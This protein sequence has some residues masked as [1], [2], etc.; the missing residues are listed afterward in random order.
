MHGWE[1]WQWTLYSINQV[2]T[3]I[4]YYAIPLAGVHAAAYAKRMGL[5]FVP[6]GLADDL[7]F[8]V[9]VFACGTH[10][11]THPVFMYLNWFWPMII[12]DLPMAVVSIIAATRRTLAAI[13]HDE[14]Y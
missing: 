5:K 8:R 3:A 13:K 12:V 1:S 6:V 10:H 14:D 4:A 2:A 9:F 7:L 11:V